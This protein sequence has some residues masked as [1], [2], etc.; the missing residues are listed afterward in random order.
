MRVQPLTVGPILGAT[1]G[2][3]ARVWGRGELEQ[4]SAGPRRCFGVARL[5][6]SDSSNYRQPIFFKM[7]PNFDMSGVIRF[8]DLSPEHEYAYQIGWLFSDLE[9]DDLGPG[10]PLDW[11]GIETLTFRTGAEDASRPRSF[12][13]GS[14][15]YMLRLFGRS[16]FDSR[17]DKTFRSILEQIEAGIRTDGILM[18]GDQI[19]AD[20][21]NILAPDVT[22]D[23][24]N[25]RYREAFSQ[26]F[27]RRLM[28]TVPTYMTLDDH[29]IEDGWP[30]NATPQDW[31]V[32][33]PAAMHAYVTYQSSHNPLLRMVAP[34]KMDGV[35]KKLWYSFTDGCCDFFVTDT[36]TER[37]LSDD[38]Y[39]RRIMS[40]AQ[41][42]ALQHW[43]VNGSGRVKFVVTAV[44]MYPD[45]DLGNDRADKWSGFVW[46]RTQLL[47]LIRREGVKRVVFLGGD[48]HESMLVELVSPGAPGFKVLSIVSSPFFWPYPNPN[49][50]RY[51]LS[52]RLDV[53]SEDV[54]QVVNSSPIIE[55]DNFVRVS[56]SLA[57]LN[58]EVFARKGELLYSTQYSLSQG[59]STPVTDD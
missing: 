55:P 16:W 14:C 49:R 5:R 51:Q 8:D 58:V 35:P 36:R 50:R 32:K 57:Q 53:T 40:D 28:S 59:A 26:P 13:F 54:F 39:E 23:A 45:P 15:R 19:Y 2:V 27:L 31:V 20:D 1:T 37:Y 21:L 48:L 46:Q 12:V 10:F 3:S 9:L 56:V 43:L 7:N 38:V 42:A 30:A 29:E 44:P 4:T 33:Y 24:Y 47:D 22:L 25:E 52:G 18:L 34:N 41:L 6:A 17:G 11:S